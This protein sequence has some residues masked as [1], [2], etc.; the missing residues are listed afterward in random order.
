[1]P[2]LDQI[3]ILMEERGW[4]KQELARRAGVSR[5]TIVNMFRR[6][7]APTPSTLEALAEAFGV[8]PAQLFGFSGNLVE[9][10]PEQRRFFSEWAALTREEKRIVAEV[11]RQFHRTRP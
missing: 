6:G 11:V 4:S 3:K 2:I 5:S 9:L 7:T 8:S 10:S 1:M